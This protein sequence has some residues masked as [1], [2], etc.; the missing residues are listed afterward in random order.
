MDEMI[1]KLSIKDRICI[2]PAMVRYH[3]VGHY[4]WALASVN[5]TDYATLACPTRQE[6]REEALCT[7]RLFRVAAWV[8]NKPLFRHEPVPTTTPSFDPAI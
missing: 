5:N 8:E 7:G 1:P 4:T 2:I 6:A 3:T